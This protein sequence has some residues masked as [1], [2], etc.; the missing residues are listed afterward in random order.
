MPYESI[1][2]S[3]SKVAFLAQSDLM[4]ILA[5]IVTPTNSQISMQ[6]QVATD[7]DVTFALQEF[8]PPQQ[9]YNNRK[10]TL[11]YRG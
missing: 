1:F 2:G 5:P 4:I 11:T 9:H 7:L 6:A 10:K 8:H 3:N